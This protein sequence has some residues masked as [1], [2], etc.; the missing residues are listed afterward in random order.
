LVLGFA[1]AVDGQDEG[2]LA[3]ADLRLGDVH[4]LARRASFHA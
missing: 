3:C 1:A 2:E 4:V